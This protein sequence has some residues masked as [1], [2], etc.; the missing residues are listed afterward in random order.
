MHNKFIKN[1]KFVVRT[2]FP[3]FYKEKTGRG[4]FHFEFQEAG[5]KKELI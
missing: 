5:N 2:Y 4:S 3:S 1:K